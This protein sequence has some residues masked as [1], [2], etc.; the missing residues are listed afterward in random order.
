LEFG[1]GLFDG[2]QVKDCQGDWGDEDI[3]TVGFQFG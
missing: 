3:F 2:R 1:D